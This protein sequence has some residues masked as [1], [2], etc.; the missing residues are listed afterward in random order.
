MEQHVHEYKPKVPLCWEFKKNG[1]CENEGNGCKFDH[2]PERLLVLA[3]R[4]QIDCSF[5][6]ATGE[7][8]FGQRCQYRHDP[9]AHKNHLAWQEELQRRSEILC[10][11]FF[12]GNCVRA[13]KCHYS[14]DEEK[15][16]AFVREL[17]RRKKIMCNNFKNGHCQYGERC[18]YKHGNEQKVK[19]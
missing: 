1:V 14:H 6:K 2:D 18:H 15:R 9:E 12:N 19:N 16:I 11:N 5:Y 3:E 17:Q 7:C 13:E 10:M 8:N 4:S